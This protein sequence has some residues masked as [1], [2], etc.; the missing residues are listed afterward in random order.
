MQDSSTLLAE[1][2]PRKVQKGVQPQSAIDDIVK[3][4]WARPSNSDAARSTGKRKGGQDITLRQQ[5]K[6]T[7]HHPEKHAGEAPKLHQRHVEKFT[8]EHK[9]KGDIKR[10]KKK[11]EEKARVLEQERLAALKYEKELKAEAEAKERKNKLEQAKA[12]KVQRD[13]Y[14]PEVVNVSNLAK[15]LGIRLEQ[16][17]STM[18]ALE[19]PNTKHDHMLTADESSLIA[20]ELDMNPIVDSQAA[21]DL[22]P[23]QQP[24]DMSIF[25]SKPPV[26]TIMGHVDHG[27]TTLLDT[28]RKSSVAAGEAGGITQHIGAFSVDLPS[29]KRITFLDTPGHAAFS[30][31]RSRGANVTDIVVLVVAADDGVMPQT[32][33]AIKHAQAANVP[34]I[35]AVNKCDK[36]G[37]D[38]HRVKQELLQHEIQLEEL[39]GD[40]PSV[41]VSGLTGKGLDELEENIVT[42]AEV[43]DLR[44]ERNNTAEGVVLE[45]NIEKGRGNVATVLVRTGTL[46]PGSN[47]VAGNALCKVRSMTDDKGKP[48]KEALPGMPVKVIGWKEL[49]NAGDEMLQAPS[50][51]V[52]KT[53]VANRI[54][55]VQRKQQLED[56]EVINDKRRRQREQVEAER[57]AERAYKKEM[58]MF[59]QGLITQYPE[60]LNKRLSDIQVGNTP[61]EE[62]EDKVKELR[63]IIKGD[64]SGTVE[65]VVD[66][67]NGLHTP[68][69]RVKVVS[70]GVGNIS[71][72][73]IQL[74][75]ACEGHVIGFN[76]KADKRIQQQ[77][78]ISN[79]PV[80]SYNVIYKLLDD[81]KASLCDMLPPI[82]S[83]QVNGEAT[84]LQIFQ[85]TV[86]GRDTKPIAGCRITNG[87]VTRNGR[88]RVVRNK[89]TIW[90]GEL[91]TLKQV[92]KDIS[93]AKKGL[94]CGMAF[95]GFTDFKEGDI[96]QSIQTIETPR[97]F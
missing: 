86:K 94:E 34:I 17:I 77:A 28:L 14:I 75:A 7:D 74:A 31:M 50:E 96:I 32:V 82:I 36:H 5:P 39:G 63:A 88:V 44:A 25:P 69:V 85:I 51:S 95:E 1:A 57:N 11:E 90:E 66:C 71:E 49:P 72:S 2:K 64:V 84:V 67:L 37:A 9:H 45:S 42:L 24:E 19:M 93:E 40:I 47:V 43:L 62:A 78:S 60:T 13:V 58:W 55:K 97:T 70:S 65:A 73:D 35:V 79:V 91:D 53:V 52:A 26:V 16:M 38:P 6:P 81:V 29:K 27:K 12:E 41:D 76:V 23:R 92:K 61:Q 3:S 48:V 89:E 83:T 10:S 56:L 80:K 87:S 4:K 68:E 54:A 30:A 18:Q 59:H 46:K 21:L 22:F 20:M 8:Q 33:E 15:I